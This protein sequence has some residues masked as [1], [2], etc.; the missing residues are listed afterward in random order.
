MKKNKLKKYL[1]IGGAGFI[2][3]HITDQLVKS[4][5]HVTVL[6][7]LSTGTK[8]NINPLAKFVKADIRN[9]KKNNSIL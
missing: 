4:V 8:E 3:S 1:V 9:L 2:G 5:Y 6:D 7:N